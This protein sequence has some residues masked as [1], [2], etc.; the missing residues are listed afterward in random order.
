MK[1]TSV[2]IRFINY[3]KRLNRSRLALRKANRL[4]KFD[5]KSK[6]HHTKPSHIKHLV[7]IYTLPGW[8]DFIYFCGLLTEFAKYEIEV[9]IATNSSLVNRL[10]GT[11]IK[12]CNILNLY[13]YNTKQDIKADCLLDLNWIF[14]RGIGRDTN[15]EHEINFTKDLDCYT[16]T[17]SDVLANLKLYDQYIDFSQIPH[18]S[19]RYGYIL[20]ELTGTT[21][22]IVKPILPLEKTHIIRAC[23]FLKSVNLKQKNFI[24]LNTTGAQKDRQ[25][26]EQQIISIVTHLLG[27][28][29]PILYYSPNFNIIKHFKKHQ[30]YLL[31]IPKITY[32]ELAAIIQNAKAVITPDTSIVHLGSSQ[33]VPVLAIFCENDYDYFGNHLLSETWA[34][35][36]K[37]SIVIDKSIKQTFFAKQKPISELT[38]HFETVINDFLERIRSAN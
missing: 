28:Q 11:N 21:G 18:I 3:L 1:I 32:F 25:F 38:I 19:M 24:Y 9:T 17:C 23:N 22:N 29:I 31:P 5:I 4:L 16:Y 27:K 35:L 20:N 37:N 10:H 36:S 6:R 7:I 12:N 30:K 14:G 26:S 15:Y 34:P 2:I 33:N 13:S 8:G